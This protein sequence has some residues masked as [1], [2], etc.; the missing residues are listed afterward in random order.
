[1]PWVLVVAGLTLS[2]SSKT[3]PALTAT[4]TGMPGV[5]RYAKL[6]ARPGR[7]PELSERLLEVARGLREV[8]GCQL[9]V[10][11]HEREDPDVIWVTELWASQE[12][13]DAALQ[14]EGMRAAI[15]EVLALVD[16]GRGERV[17]LVPLGGVGFEPD[18]RGF[19][20]VHLPELEDMAERFGYGEQGEARFARG[21]LDAVS[22]GLS[23]QTFR[24]GVRQAFGHRH[25]LDEEIYVVLR[26]HGLI[27][28]DDATAEIRE[29]DAIRVAAG[30][31]RAF[32]A[33]PEGLSILATG[34][35]RPG[36][37]ALL[38]GFW[39]S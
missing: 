33:G 3:A 38:P 18:Q 8:A 10:I 36:D 12:Q 21:E 23:L 11:N 2:H 39:P 32:E 34:A 35:H 15:A 7:G 13:L 24:P 19:A 22:T 16:R 28:V 6:V 1:M 37:A 31:A 9:Y 14:A 17:E 26:G 30:S 20:I 4:V 5:G 29:L 25:T 27:A